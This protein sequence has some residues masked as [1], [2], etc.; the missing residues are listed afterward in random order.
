MDQTTFRPVIRTQSDV[1][2]LWRRLMSPLGFS[3]SSLWMVFIESRRPLPQITE[4]ENL[5][6]APDDTVAD[7][8]V[9]ALENLATPH[10]SLAFLRTRPGSGSPDACDLAW[11]RTLY[12]VGNR[13]QIELET[14]HLAHDHDV[15]PIPMDSVLSSPH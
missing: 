8:L 15:L 6:A 5:P 14:I 10:A 12:A 9:R 13:A 4:V 2:R 1:E 11:A 3:S 7:G